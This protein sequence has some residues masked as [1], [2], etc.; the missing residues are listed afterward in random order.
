MKIIGI[1]GS[2]RGKESTTRRLIEAI[3]A[4]ARE[5]GATTTFI[6]LG[7]TEIR[8]CSG[9]GLCYERGE[10]PKK[11]DFQKIFDDMLAAEGIVLGSPNYINSVTAQMKT[12]LDRM[13]DAIHCQRF[14]GKYGCAVST[15]GGSRSD[16]VANYLNETLRILGANTVGG[17]SVDICGDE[18]RLFAA[19]EQAYRLGQDLARAVAEGRPYPEQETFHRE[20]EERMKALVTAHKHVWKHE[21]DY[22]AKM[23][24][25]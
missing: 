10:C 7:S 2:P 20:M 3:L 14:T 12:F 16:E 8:Y 23:G 11:D 17:V 24:Q 15:A 9:C 25:K 4:G 18:E 21:Y 6:D 1:N 13:A 19:G 22:W 5:G